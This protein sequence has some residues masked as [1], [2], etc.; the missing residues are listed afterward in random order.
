MTEVEVGAQF[1]LTVLLTRLTSRSAS[2]R[3]EKL[4]DLFHNRLRSTYSTP[5]PLPAPH[6]NILIQTLPLP[7]LLFL[8]RHPP[9]DQLP[10]D[11]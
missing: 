11:C 1:P 4:W 8:G 3:S 9:D 6:A 5:R 10:D 7:K 2:Q